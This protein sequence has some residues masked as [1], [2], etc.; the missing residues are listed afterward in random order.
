MRPIIFKCP[1]WMLRLLFTGAIAP[2]V[3]VPLVPTL[4]WPL[5]VQWVLAGVAAF[6]VLYAFTLIP[7]KLVLSDD[8]LWQKLLVSELRLRWEDMVEWRYTTGPEGDYLW[9]RDRNGRKHQPKRW[10][11]FGRRMADFAVVLQE[12]GIK[13]EIR[14]LRK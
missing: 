6:I 3:L 9:I 11:V 4:G 5:V 10:L 2:L 8:G 14:K 12:R 13:G 7:T 1:S